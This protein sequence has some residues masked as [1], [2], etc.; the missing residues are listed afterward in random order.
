AIGPLSLA[1]E[2][3]GGSVDSLNGRLYL[4][5]PA[6]DYSTFAAGSYAGIGLHSLEGTME[7]WVDVVSGG[8][9]GV[10]GTADIGSLSAGL[11][12]GKDA[13]IST[14]STRFFV[15]RQQDAWEAW[16]QDMSFDWNGAHWR[17]SN[18]HARLQPDG[19]AT[20]VADSFN[21]KV[22]VGLVSELGALD[23]ATIERLGEF[24]PRGELHNLALHYDAGQSATGEAALPSMTLSANVADGGMDA[25]RGAPAVWGVDGYAE[26]SLDGSSRKISGMVEV[27][28]SRFMIHL[29]DLF[30]D[31]WSY[32]QVNGRVR[33]TLDFAHG[34]RLRLASS[35]LTAESDVIDGRVQFATDYSS[36]D[37]GRASTLELL[38]GGL[39]ADLAGKSLYLPTGPKVP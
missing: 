7:L 27:D 32:D 25:R 24:N 34:T 22:A 36:S 5:L 17:E 15:R 26:M 16:L 33:F 19:I 35:V 10:R 38:V 21:V 13:A 20:A 11:R 2:L 39:N 14:L 30:T 6:N 4:L 8:I 12:E 29:P 3:T 31:T 37:E 18:L 28:S 1:A 23:D 9:E